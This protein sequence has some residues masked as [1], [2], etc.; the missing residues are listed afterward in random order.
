MPDVDHCILDR[1]QEWGIE[2]IDVIA[3]DGQQKRHPVGAHS[4]QRI[5][6]QSFAELKEHL[7]GAGE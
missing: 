5:D 6:L 3:V 4:Q 7:P 1:L 2:R